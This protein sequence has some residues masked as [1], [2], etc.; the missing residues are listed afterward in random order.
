MAFG[1]NI[2]LVEEAFRLLFPAKEFKYSSNLKYSG[3]FKDYGA[4]I[5]LRGDFL[6]VKLSRSWQGISREIQIGLIQE[7]LL[8]MFKKKV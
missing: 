2:N 4:T 8:R 7:L 3:H 1:D 5:S 6:Q